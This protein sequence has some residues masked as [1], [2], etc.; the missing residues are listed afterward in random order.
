MVTILEGLIICVR[1]EKDN[2]NQYN[3]LSLRDTHIHC[4]DVGEDTKVQRSW[5]EKLN[6]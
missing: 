3:M 2:I 1:L 4:S 5:G 6:H